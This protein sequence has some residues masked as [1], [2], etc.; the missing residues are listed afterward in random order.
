M[1]IHSR[2]HVYTIRVSVPGKDIHRRYKLIDLRKPIIHPLLAY[3]AFRHF[4]VIIIIFII[5]YWNT[6]LTIVK[7]KLLA[8][9]ASISN[10]RP[11]QYS[12]VLRFSSDDDIH[13]QLTT[14]WKSIV[15][16]DQRSWPAPV[17]NR[18]AC[19]SFRGHA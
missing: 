15:N 14:L 4:Y 11:A 9:P 12:A 17:I 5:I 6:F 16:A 13:V 10:G 7:S 1:H 8:D 18:A 2:T 3:C 19:P